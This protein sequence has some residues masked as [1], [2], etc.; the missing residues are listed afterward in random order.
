MVKHKKTKNMEATKTHL[1]PEDIDLLKTKIMKRLQ[2]AEDILAFVEI[3]S[4]REDAHT[5]EDILL[6]T[7]LDSSLPV[8]QIQLNN[9]METLRLCKKALIRIENKCYGFCLRTG[10]PIPID[11]LNAN[12]IKETL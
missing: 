11:I 12:P 7:C 10:T 6:N 8:R 1:K 5:E 3:T 2:R 4:K 9:A